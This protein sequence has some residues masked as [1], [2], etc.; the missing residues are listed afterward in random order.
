MLT[1]DVSTGLSHGR[2]R[3]E[4]GQTPALVPSFIKSGAGIRAGSVQMKSRSLL[5]QRKHG[6]DFTRIYPRTNRY[7]ADSRVTHNNIS[8]YETHWRES[9]KNQSS[10][11]W[12]WPRRLTH[13]CRVCWNTAYSPL[14]YC[15]PFNSNDWEN[16]VNLP[17]SSLC[18]NTASTRC[19]SQREIGQKQPSRDWTH[20]SSEK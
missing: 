11:G 9:I 2:S 14:N 6:R 10:G 18:L 8:D 4:E 1:W 5:L 20:H 7:Q 19:C 13:L 12:A 17:L 3:I 15:F 16:C